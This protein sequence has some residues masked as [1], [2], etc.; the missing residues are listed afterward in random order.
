MYLEEET[1]YLKVVN[2]I[3][4]FSLVTNSQWILCNC[5][6]DNMKGKKID[7]RELIVENGDKINFRKNT[8]NEMIISFCINLNY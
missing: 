1:L 5:N 2:K 4:W 6:M 8:P 7:K 3:F